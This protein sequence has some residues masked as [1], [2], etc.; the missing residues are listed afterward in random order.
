MSMLFL[1]GVRAV[2]ETLPPGDVL[3]QYINRAK[4]A[5]A[6]ESTIASLQSQVEAMRVALE[7]FARTVERV[8]LPGDTEDSRVVTSFTVGDFRRARATT[9]ETHNG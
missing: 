2:L 8:V 1:P 4:R 3:Q 7:P 6:A 5:E 9:Q